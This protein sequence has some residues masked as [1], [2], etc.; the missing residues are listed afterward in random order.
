MF[1]EELPQLV[2]LRA[3][4]LLGSAFICLIAFAVSLLVILP[5]SIGRSTSAGDGLMPAFSDWLNMSLEKHCCHSDSSSWVFA[6]LVPSDF[7]T[8]AAAFGVLFPDSSFTT[9]QMT[10]CWLVSDA[11]LSSSNFPSKCLISSCS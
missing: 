5:V 10:S 7:F 3:L 11:C 2:H 9:F 8:F 1:D 6:T 4:G